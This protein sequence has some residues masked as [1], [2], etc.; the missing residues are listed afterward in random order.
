MTEVQI[1]AI[2]AAHWEGVVIRRNALERTQRT[3][4]MRLNEPF[5]ALAIDQSKVC[6]NPFMSILRFQKGANA[7]FIRGGVKA[8]LHRA[9]SFHPARSRENFSPATRLMAEKPPPV[10]A[11]STSSAPTFARPEPESLFAT[12]KK[13]EAAAEASSS[14]SSPFA[15]TTTTTFESPYKHSPYTFGGIA[16][17]QTTGASLWSS[18]PSLMKP[19]SGVTFFNNPTPS[20]QSGYIANNIGNG[21][22]S[23]AAVVS[24]TSNVDIRNRCGKCYG[25]K[26]VPPEVS[27]NLA[28]RLMHD[29][30]VAGEWLAFYSG[31]WCS[32]CSGTGVEPD[33]KT[34]QNKGEVPLHESK[35]IKGSY[36]TE[37]TL[38]CPSCTR[39]NNNRNRSNLF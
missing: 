39:G 22:G 29:T 28:P 2:V 37:T 33:C 20:P 34:C 38:T 26:F 8:F 12:V 5:H 10:I 27:P 23:G 24:S 15:T 9:R 3:V 4:R 17:M 13:A 19:V 7:I 11:C 16:P 31:V 30:N 6:L 14:S 35:Q 32:Q 21:S 1:K 36:R 25:F 18:S